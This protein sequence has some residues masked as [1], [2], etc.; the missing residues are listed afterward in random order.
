LS[1]LARLARW[2]RQERGSFE[3]NYMGIV[4]VCQCQIDDRQR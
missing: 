1:P 3:C 2:P 4:A